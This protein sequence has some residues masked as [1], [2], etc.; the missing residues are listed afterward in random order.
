M[1]AVCRHWRMTP[2]EYWRLTGAEEAMLVKHMNKEAAELA[3]AQR[4]RRRKGR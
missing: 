1:A 3:R 2:E 4:R